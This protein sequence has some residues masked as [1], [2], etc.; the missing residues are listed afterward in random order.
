M[1]YFMKIHIICI[2][3]HMRNKGTRIVVSKLL[4]IH[5]FLNKIYKHRRSGT[6]SQLQF[7]AA[8]VL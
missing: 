2:H 5:I 6:A 4:K 1:N 3:L 8:A 7:S